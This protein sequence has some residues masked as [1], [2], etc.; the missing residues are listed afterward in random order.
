MKTIY[1][2]LTTKEKQLTRKVS[3]TK[4]E[5]LF[6]ENDVCHEVGI[7]IKGVISI[8]SY[9]Y[10]GEEMNYN[11]ILEGGVFGN[12]LIFSSDPIYKGNVISK[13]K[14][15]VI[16][17]AKDNLVSILMNNES[18]LKEYLK[19]QSNFGKVLNQKI[20]I[21]SFNTARDRL[22]FLLNNAGGSI[23][24]RSVSSLAESLNLSREA[25]SRLISSLQKENLLVR[26]GNL[27][28]L[29]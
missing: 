10:K 28:K 13:M 22:L 8:S 17:I 7:V 2:L 14:S 24:F 27:I 5:T 25:T 19:I 11:T 4:D 16:L 9:S 18:F 21:L 15:E 1:D 20:K 26:E 23:K 12:N 6:Y 3:L 29:I